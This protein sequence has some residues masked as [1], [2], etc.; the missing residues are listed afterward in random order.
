MVRLIAL[1]AV[2]LLVL[3]VLPVAATTVKNPVIRAG[4]DPWMTLPEGTKVD[5]E[6]NP[7]PAGFFCTASTAFTGR[8]WLRGVPLASDN[9]Q[10]AKIDTIV[11]RLDDAVFD[12]LGVAQTRF[13]V[14]ALQLE[15]V[16]TFKNQCGEYHV[17]VTLDGEQPITSMRIVR[18]NPSGGRFLV[19]VKINTKVVF[20]RV[21]NPAEKLE[22]AY[23][24]TFKPSP[25]HSWSLREPSDTR[26]TSGVMVDTDWDGA[27]DTR[28][29]GM[30]NFAAGQDR[31]GLRL[32]DHSCHMVV[33][34]NPHGKGDRGRRVTEN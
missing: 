10:Y 31:S 2:A 14:R 15:G 24:V 26:Q 33:Y 20:T 21:D 28:V 13:Q 4:I 30:S 23:P 19:T 1:A 12:S 22:F 16:G 27:P 17:Q 34:P 25:Y 32:V 11:E 18:D 5:F 3:T 7:L 8:I 6:Q 9:P 29:R